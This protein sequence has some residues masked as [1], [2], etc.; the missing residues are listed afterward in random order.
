M[1]VMCAGEHE[2]G[3]SDRDVYVEARRLAE[4]IGAVKDGRHFL[5]GRS[6]IKVPLTMVSLGWVSEDELTGVC[7]AGAVALARLRLGLTPDLP[8]ALN[9]VE[10]VAVEVAEPPEEFITDYLDEYLFAPDLE[11]NPDLARVAQERRAAVEYYAVTRAI[12]EGGTPYV[13]SVLD[14]LVEASS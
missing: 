8:G 6:G 9:I 14:R 3:V 1:N 4:E 2:T 12:E 10:R 13:C 5:E 7:I 11:P